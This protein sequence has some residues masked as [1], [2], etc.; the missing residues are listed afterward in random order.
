MRQ[1]Q[2]P[3]HLLQLVPVRRVQRGHFGPEATALVEMSCAPKPRI[4]WWRKML[5]GCGEDIASVGAGVNRWRAPH[6]EV[7]RPEPPIPHSLDPGG[8]LF[9]GRPDHSRGWAWH[10][11]QVLTGSEIVC[12]SG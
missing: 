12:L 11:C 9:R 2:P 7:E 8:P 6:A 4:T 3:R 5:W 1:V 10:K